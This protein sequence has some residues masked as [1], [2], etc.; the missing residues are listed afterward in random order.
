MLELSREMMKA[1]ILQEMVEDALDPV[2]DPLIDEDQEINKIMEEIGGYGVMRAKLQEPGKSI[3]LPELP[4]DTTADIS[5][6][7][8]EVNKEVEEVQKRLA[9]LRS[10]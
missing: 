5:E 10:S 6:D 4:D 8:G 1:G 2:L 7:V 9:E 3:D